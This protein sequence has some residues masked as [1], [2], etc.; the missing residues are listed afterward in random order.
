MGKKAARLLGLRFVDSDREIER[1]TGM[2]VQDIFKK[3][4]ETRFRSEEKAA[5]TRIT[6]EDNQVIS[7]G[8]GVVLNPE[9]INALKKNGIL[10]CLTADPEVILE[11][12][13]KKKNRPLLM[14]DDPLE[15][16]NRLL[17]ERAHLYE[18]A[19]ETVDTSGRSL[20]EVLE[21]VAGI[22][23]KYRTGFKKKGTSGSR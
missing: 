11:R 13:K 21:E 15:T 22:Y 8:G 4:G 5:I 1:I 3:H 23:E 19:A 2:S 7:T 16:I 6:R 10:V 20:D 18:C 17:A 12:V 14:N 9:N